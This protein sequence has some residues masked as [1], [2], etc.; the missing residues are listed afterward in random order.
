M[1][2]GIGRSLSAPLLV[3]NFF[4]YLISACLAGWALNRNL[5]AT[6]GLGEGPVGE[7]TG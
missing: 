3:L 1:A 6:T 2:F 7:W 5:D 4:L